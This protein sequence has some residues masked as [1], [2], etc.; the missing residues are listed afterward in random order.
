MRRGTVQVTSLVGR[1]GEAAVENRESIVAA[2]EEISR[3]W[4]EQ[5]QQRTDKDA[6]VCI[7]YSTVEMGIEPAL[8][9]PVR[10]LEGS[11][12]LMCAARRGTRRPRT[13]YPRINF[14][15]G[16]DG[17]TL[18]TIRTVTQILLDNYCRN[19]VDSKAQTSRI[20]AAGCYIESW[21]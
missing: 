21:A 11:G 2:D 7:V 6:G 5:Q 20:A 15:Q 12:S 10:S 13:F 8:G 4:Q 16:W 17:D 14:Y 19:I 3:E 18:C 9:V 1:R